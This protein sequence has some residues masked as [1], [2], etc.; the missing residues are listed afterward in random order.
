MKI[1]EKYLSRCI[2]LAKNGLGLT[3]PNPMVG[4]VV[5]WNDKIIGEGWHQKAGGPH[6][7]VHAINSVK[8]KSLLKDATI[9]VSLEPCSHYG[10]TPPCVDLI[11][12][13]KIP[14]VVIGSIDTNSLVAGKGVEHL[15][16]N[17]CNVEV[18]VLEKDCLELNKRF[19]TYH[20]KRRPYIILKW[21]T[22]NDG[23]FDVDR[24]IS[25]LADAKPTWI[26]NTYA[27]Q[28]V[29]Q[30]RTGEQAILVGTKTVLKD[31]PKLDA[32]NFSGKN[33]IRVV[34]DK[35]LKISLNYQ[36]FNGKLKTI[37]I[38]DKGTEV[39]NFLTT[40]SDLKVEKIDFQNNIVLQ[41]LEVLYKH[42]IQS[43]IVEG[44]KQLLE[45]FINHN[46]WDE[47]FVFKGKV[48][49]K[50]GIKSPEIKEKWITQRDVLGE[51]VSF[52]KNSITK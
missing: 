35:S 38:A 29:H 6:A 42:E 21:A 47:A 45:S 17:G 39:A 7:E 23:Y 19:Y 20:N 50:G 12:Q 15:K 14:N 1:H 32:R 41:I 10:K 37:V 13:S 8:D 33:P 27:Q 9:Y 30:L 26:T 16:N 28:L 5:V 25:D 11:V 3:Y 4:A 18:G 34:L 31:N 46:L 51:T 2:E 40:I 24:D 36:V 52:Y 48:E 22:S 43:L 44:G 49:L